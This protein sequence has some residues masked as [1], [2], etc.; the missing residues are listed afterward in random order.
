MTMF[1]RFTEIITEA[2]SAMNA[3]HESEKNI[4]RAH[5]EH[6]VSCRNALPITVQILEAPS[7]PMMIKDIKKDPN[8]LYFI[9]SGY[10]REAIRRLCELH[11]TKEDALSVKI[12]GLIVD[13]AMEKN[14][15]RGTIWTLSIPKR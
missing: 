10:R 4:Y 15:E 6:L 11:A 14:I 1:Q 3:A 9:R 2:E 7:T 8:F 13:E 5:I 12:A